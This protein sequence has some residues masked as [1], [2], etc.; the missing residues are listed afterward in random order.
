MEDLRI[1]ARNQDDPQLWRELEPPV[2]VVRRAVGRNPNTGTA[3]WSK[4]RGGLFEHCSGTIKVFEAFKRLGYEFLGGSEIDECALEFQRRVLS[5]TD[6]GPVGFWSNPVGQLTREE[7][8]RLILLIGSLQCTEF[9]LVNALQKGA[10]DRSAW[11]AVEII[12]TLDDPDI[13]LEAIAI[14]N[15]PA[16]E[17]DSE[18]PAA[19]K[20]AAAKHD[21]T[22]QIIKVL[23]S[24]HGAAHAR[25]RIIIVLE[26][27]D[28]TREL[29]PIEDPGPTHPP[30]AVSTIL[31]PRD[32]I[33]AGHW[34]ERA[35]VPYGGVQ[36]N[37]PYLQQQAAYLESGGTRRVVWDIGHPGW[38]TR[39]RESESLLLDNREGGPARARLQVHAT[40]GA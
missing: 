26:P 24:H 15:V 39:T 18:I 20:E 28:R 29:G 9:S 1:Q 38:S 27:G 32:Q 31:E 12:K 33:P 23:T 17:Q 19:Y 14:E 3:N 16:W 10:A 40:G 2:A 34:A 25:R 11:M 21:W 36:Y 13:K 22:M 7:K 8:R 37:S 4:E 30:V 5:L 6:A 35:L